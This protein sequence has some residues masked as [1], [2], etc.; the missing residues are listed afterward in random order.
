MVRTVLIKRTFNMKHA[1][2][3]LVALCGALLLATPTFSQGPTFGLKG[4]LNYTN[5]AG[6]DADDNNARVGFNAGVFARTM[7]ESPVG[8]QLE[9]LYSTKGNRT[10]YNA[11]FGLVEQDVD[12]NLNYLELPVMASIRV[13]DVVD[14]QIGGYAAYLLSGKVKT[15]GDLGSGS[16]EIDKSDFTSLDAGIVGG[17]GFNVGENLQIGMRYL[18]GLVDVIDD[19]TLSAVVGDAQNRC[20]QVYLAV[21]VGGN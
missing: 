14:F 8:V 7:P 9:L 15:S 2:L 5:L 4:G 11:F 12:F 16:G 13:M 21:G 19:S 17:I 18:H 6:L 10:T 1:Y 3:N 20:L